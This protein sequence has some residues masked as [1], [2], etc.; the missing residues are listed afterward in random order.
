VG[1]E[2]SEVQDKPSGSLFL[3]PEDPD[4]GLSATSP[5][6]YLPT[7]TMLPTMMTMD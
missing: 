1:F 5:A 3:L 7:A 4:V 2:V 6:A